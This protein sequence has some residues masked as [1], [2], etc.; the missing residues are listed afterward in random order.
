[1]THPGAPLGRGE[2]WGLDRVAA[3]LDRA[4]RQAGDGAVTGLLENTAGPGSQLGHRFEHLRDIRRASDCP[5][6]LGVLLV[7]PS[8]QIAPELK[9][10]SG[11]VRTDATLC[12]KLPRHLR[13]WTR[14]PPRS[15]H[16]VIAPG[17]HEPS[18]IY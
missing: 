2:R 14:G 12:E 3:A 11:P 5:A 9:M 6:R 17:D 8:I 16:V 1:V 4:F 18:Y 7:Q 15:R 10:A 13:L